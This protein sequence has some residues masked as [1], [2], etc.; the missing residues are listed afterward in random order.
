MSE[1]ELWMAAGAVGIVMLIGY[2][3]YSG[4]KAKVERCKKDSHWRQ[5]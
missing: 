4:Y 3:I 1:L 2:R 5:N